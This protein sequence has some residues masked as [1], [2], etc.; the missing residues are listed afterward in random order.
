MT[1][2]GL[3]LFVLCTCLHPLSCLF[4]PRFSFFLF[5]LPMSAWLLMVVLCFV[6]RR[7]RVF[8]VDRLFLSPSHTRSPRSPF[9]DQ[10]DRLGT[11][12]G[13]G[14]VRKKPQPAHAGYFWPAR[15]LATAA[16]HRPT[17]HTH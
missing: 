14:V 3:H 8:V 4:S 1:T 5:S 10:K 9:P 7:M 11:W 16:A 15:A 17:G 13:L 2:R 6:S 12:H